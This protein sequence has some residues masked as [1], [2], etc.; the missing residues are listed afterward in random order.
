M[1]I[2]RT[3]PIEG[4]ET[5]RPPMELMLRELPAPHR[6]VLVATYF[7]R[8][9]TREAAQLLGIPPAEVS[10]RLY[11]AMRGLA[12]KIAVSAT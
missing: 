9:T 8:R 12:G 11:Q 6:E 7:H 3:D 5:Q 4:R 2:T 1:P 10:A